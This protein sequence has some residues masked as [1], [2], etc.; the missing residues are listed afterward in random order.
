VRWW[1]W[2]GLAGLVGAAAVGTAVVVKQRQQREWT[3]YEPD[4]L[5]D[6]L[7]ERLQSAADS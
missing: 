3:E 7:H 5:R 4:E 6:K 1:K 2:V